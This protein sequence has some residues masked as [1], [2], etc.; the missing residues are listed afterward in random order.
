MESAIELRELT[1]TYGSRRGLTSLSLDVRVGEIFGYLGPNG[2]GKTTTIRLLLD[3]IRPTAGRAT[4]LGLDART[5]GVALCRRV[6]Y[7]PGDFVVDG[8]QRA[9]DCLH[10]LADLR[11][12]VPPPASPVPNAGSPQSRP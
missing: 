1:K 7:L 4:I 9:R 10:F 2:A 5:D 8:R 6:G 12:G 3:L 11:G